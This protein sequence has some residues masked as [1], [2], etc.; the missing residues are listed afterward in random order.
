M[1]GDD[2]GEDPVCRM[3]RA[4]HVLSDEQQYERHDQQE[5]AD[6]DRIV[7]AD[8]VQSVAQRRLECIDQH[9]KRGGQ[10]EEFTH[11]ASATELWTQSIPPP[12]CPLSGAAAASGSRHGNG[13]LRWPVPINTRVPARCHPSFALFRTSSNSPIRYY[14][15]SP[16]ILAVPPVIL[17]KERDPG[18]SH[19]VRADWILAFAGMTIWAESGAPTVH[20]RCHWHDREFACIVS[21]HSPVRGHRGCYSA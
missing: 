5:V 8:R 20:C 10:Q 15:R 16:G 17:A 3:N 14:H 18:R 12:S 13:A 7:L 21:Q 11:H 6:E 2:D 19:N 9:E 1:H 4:A